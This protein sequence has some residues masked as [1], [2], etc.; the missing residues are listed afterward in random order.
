MEADRIAQTVDVLVDQ[1]R[2]RTSDPRL[3]P[4]RVPKQFHEH[5]PFSSARY[6]TNWSTALSPY[7]VSKPSFSEV[8]IPT[9]PI[10]HSVVIL[11]KKQP[12]YIL[13]PKLLG[14]P[15]DRSV[16]YERRYRSGSPLAEKKQA[17]FR[18]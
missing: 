7:A 9:E 13:W 10:G 12:I 6:S 11:E 18:L 15:P 4:S 8:P 2:T 5:V 16:V 14:R 3:P 17:R 1:M